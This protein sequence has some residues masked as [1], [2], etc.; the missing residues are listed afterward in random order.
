MITELVIRNFKGIKDQSFRFE[1]FDLLVGQNNSGKSTI[2]H[3]LAI[4]QFCVDEFHRANR[5]GA[6]GIQIVLPNFTVLPLPEFNLLWNDK[7]DRMYPVID[8]K[9]KQKYILIEIGVFWRNKKNEEVRFGIKLRYQGPLSIY[10]IPDGGW[11]YFRK[12]DADNTLP[13]VVYV[14]PFSGL[15]PQEEWSDD[16]IIRRNV[17]KAQPGSVLRNLLYRVLD[18]THAS[19]QGETPDH[20]DSE[21]WEEIVKKIQEWFGVTLNKPEYEKGVSVHI[22]VTF[23]V[24]ATGKEFDVVTGGSGFHQVLTLFAFLY[25]YP[26]ITTILL[27]EPDA[28]MHVNLQRNILNYFLNSDKVSSQFIIATHA[29]EF[30]K[31]V[32]PHQI[33]SVLSAKPKRVEEKSSVIA[34]LSDVTNMTVVKTLDSPYVLYVEGEDDERLLHAWAQILERSEVLSKFCIEKMGGGSKREMFQNANSHFKGLKQTVPNVERFIL[35]DYDSKESF[36]PRKNNP[37]LFEWARKNI[38]NYLLVSSAWEKAILKELGDIP[39]LFSQHLLKI[40]VDF[41]NE[42]SLT[43]PKGFGWK[44]IKANIFSVVDGKEILFASPDSLFQRIKN[45][46][47]SPNFDGLKINR[48][49]V[50]RNMKKEELHSD[51]EEFFGKLKA[52]LL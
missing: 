39:P 14:P 47:K 31:G 11:K 22:K 44:N 37:V 27:D 41:F 33:V 50:A 17:G 36:H 9:K 5:K 1:N 29:E 8:G 25:G 46:S 26:N 52:V 2:L 43:L 30:I 28:H 15:E 45:E 16:A 49:S 35:F 7:T 23:T 51:I 42:Q 48:E 38:E 18:K 32:A 21:K 6:A 4:W 34:A 40:V 3:A 24:K 13:R 10:A 20:R 12:L 19:Q